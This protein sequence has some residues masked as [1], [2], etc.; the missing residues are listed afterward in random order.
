MH[1]TLSLETERLLQRKLSSGEYRSAD[2]VLLA[3][4][5][6]LDAADHL[7]QTAFDAIDRA[8]DQIE[9]GQVREWKDVREQVRARFLGK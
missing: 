5:E 6:A 1:I 4:L 9:R 7:D 2:E 8:E 3:A